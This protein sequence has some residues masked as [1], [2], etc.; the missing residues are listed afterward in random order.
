MYDTQ[1]K[2][3]AGEKFGVF[4]PRYSQNWIL[5]ENLTLRCTQTGHIFPKSVHFFLYFQ[6]RAWETF[7]IPPGSSTPVVNIITVA[8]KTNRT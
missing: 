1:K 6:K 8:C 4:C 2:G 7:P 5:N 3:P